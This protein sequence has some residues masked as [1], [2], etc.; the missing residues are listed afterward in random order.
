MAVDLINKRTILKSILE[1]VEP[2]WNLEKP[3]PAD[4]CDVDYKCIFQKS[5]EYKQAEVDIPNELFFD[6]AH[7]AIE[8]LVR[9]AI[10]NAKVSIHS[11]TACQ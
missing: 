2:G 4:P 8:S 7:A 5:S 11:S 6:S 10:K 1:K 3:S 9:G